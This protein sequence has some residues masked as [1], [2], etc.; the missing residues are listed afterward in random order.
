MTTFKKRTL[1]VALAAGLGLAWSSPSLANGARPLGMGD[2]FIAV[3]DDENAMFYN[4]AGMAQID[5]SMAQSSFQVHERGDFERDS[6]SFVGKVLTETDKERVT[7]EEYLESDYTFKAEVE[8]VANY[9]WGGA[10]LHE[11]RSVELNQASG[12]QPPTRD[13]KNT[14]MLALSTRFPVLEK[15][16]RRPELYVGLRGRYTDLERDIPSLR[17]STA[18]DLLDLDAHLFYRANSRFHMGMAVNSIINETTH[19]VFGAKAFSGTV[20][21]GF[22]YYFG[23]RRDTIAALDF[24][25]VFN[26]DRARQ[27]KIKVGAERQFLDNDLAVRIGGNDGLLTLG[28]GLRF[29]EDFRIDYAFVNGTIQ[30]EHQVSARLNF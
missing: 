28:F 18:Q 4:V 25:N 5:R 19:E 3:A 12:I 13:K 2:A 23:E 11:M 10:F 29:W 22:A 6:S 15:L 9:S 1:A 7:L 27:P 30:D 17:T 14:Y 26:A 16:T 20:D 21:M 8:K 24:T